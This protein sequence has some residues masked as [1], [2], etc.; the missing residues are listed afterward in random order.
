MTDAQL[1]AKFMGLSVGILPPDRVRTTMD[2]SLEDRAVDRC[3]RDR[4][5]GYGLNLRTERMPT[6]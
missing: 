4:T 3:R 1:E 5:L 2:L 6:L